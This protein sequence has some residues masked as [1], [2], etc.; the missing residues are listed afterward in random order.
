[1]GCFWGVERGRCVRLTTLRQ[2]VSRLSRQCG[3]L[4]ITQP[5]RPP[6]TV[7]EIASLCVVFIV[8][9]VSLI[10]Y[11]TLCVFCL[12]VVCYFV[13]CVFLCV[14]SYCSTVPPGKNQFEVQL[15]N[16]NDK[17]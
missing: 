7:R 5:Y 15:T 10:V 4:D 8:C 16:N 3:I 9:N 14:V 11:V 12:S 2:S 1:M 17:N 13:L 6:R